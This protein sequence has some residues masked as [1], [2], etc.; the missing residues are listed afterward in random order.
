[1]SGFAVVWYALNAADYT[2]TQL[3]LPIYARLFSEEQVAYFSAMPGWVDG[4]WAIGVWGGLLGALLMWGG[5]RRAAAMLAL[6]PLG[7][8]LLTLWLLVVSRPP[9]IALTGWAG[10]W[11]M[12]GSVVVS[13]L[14]WVYARAMHARG[15]LP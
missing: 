9:M 5:R 2:G 3:R 7:L 13:A 15:H 6:G 8:A 12:V 4:I 11:I 1:M 10:V 14:V